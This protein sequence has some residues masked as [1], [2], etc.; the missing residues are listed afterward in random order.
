MPNLMILGAHKLSK[1]I[2][3]LLTLSHHLG[4]FLERKA[5]VSGTR[6]KLDYC[7]RNW[8]FNKDRYL[9]C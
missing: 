1:T 4:Y 3:L 8:D 2:D 5:D 9:M 6:T 7:S